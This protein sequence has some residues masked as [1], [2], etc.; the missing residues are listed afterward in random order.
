[1]GLFLNVFILNQYEGTNFVSV[2]IPYWITLG[3]GFLNA[4]LPMHTIN[5]FLYTP[6][7]EDVPVR[8]LEEARKLFKWPYVSLSE[9]TQLYLFFETSS[10]TSTPTQPINGE[11][12]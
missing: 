12:T 6:N 5:E 2:P 7:E 4:L 11:S 9:L 10:F 8:T 1:M 3:I